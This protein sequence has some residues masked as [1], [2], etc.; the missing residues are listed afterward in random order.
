MAQG[1]RPGTC[2]DPEGW[3]GASGGSEA[4]EGGKICIRT[5]DSHGCTPETNTTLKGNYTP[6]KK[7][8][9]LPWWSSG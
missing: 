8:G 9:G 3:D 5:A 6:Q 1:A 4:Q 2:D 7:L